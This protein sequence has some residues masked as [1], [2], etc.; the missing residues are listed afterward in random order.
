MPIKP[1]QAKLFPFCTNT[2]YAE[3]FA[4]MYDLSAKLSDRIYKIYN[5]N[6]GVK[7][8]VKN[9]SSDTTNSLD[10]FLIIIDNILYWSKCRCQF[11][12]EFS[13]KAGGISAFSAE[14]NWHFRGNRREVNA[15]EGRMVQCIY[16]CYCCGLF[17]MAE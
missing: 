16:Y 5:K 8:M 12:L 9:I 10:I 1:K 13:T 6:R 3:N 4:K 2:E 11:Q 14:G 15:F 17:L 7:K